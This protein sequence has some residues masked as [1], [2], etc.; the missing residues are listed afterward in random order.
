LKK[1][2]EEDLKLRKE[3][4]EAYDK[5]RAKKRENE[6]KYI[7]EVRFITTKMDILE[8]KVKRERSRNRKTT[9]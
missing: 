4:Q 3:F 1:A 2:T 8:K 6:M 5:L 7:A 9:L